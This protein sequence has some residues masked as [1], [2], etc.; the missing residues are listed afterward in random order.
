MVREHNGHH[1]PKAYSVIDLIV[2]IIKVWYPG[3]F[4]DTVKSA[5]AGV[6]KEYF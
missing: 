3:T 1:S 2:E 6:S 4:L 5:T